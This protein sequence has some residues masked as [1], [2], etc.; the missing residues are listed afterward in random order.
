MKINKALS[1]TLIASVFVITLAGC[2]RDGPLEEAGEKMDDS[3]DDAGDA[4][5]DATDGN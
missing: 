1:A 5:E 4:I 3:I 2:D